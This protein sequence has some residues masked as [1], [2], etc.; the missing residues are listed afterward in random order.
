ML[1]EILPQAVSSRYPL[2]VSYHALPLV[3]TFM[4]VLYPV[5]RPLSLLLDFVLGAP[6]RTIYANEEFTHLLE[7]HRQAGALDDEQSKIMTGAINFKTATVRDCYT[8]IEKLYA[9]EMDEVINRQKMKEIFTSGYSRIPVYAKDRRRTVGM[10]L[11]KDLILVDPKQRRTVGE[12]AG[13]FER[14]P[15]FFTLDQTLDVA[16]ELFKQGRSHC[17]I[18]EV[19]NGPNMD[20][21]GMVTLEDIMEEI[22]HAEIKDE[23]EDPVSQRL[24]TNDPTFVDRIVNLTK[25]S[26]WRPRG[27]RSEPESSDSDEESFNDSIAR[28]QRPLKLLAPRIAPLP[29]NKRLVRVVSDACNLLA[30]RLQ[31]IVKEVQVLDALGI[32]FNTI[33]LPEM[34]VSITGNVDVGGQDKA[35]VPWYSQERDSYSAVF[36]VSLFVRALDGTGISRRVVFNSSDAL[37]EAVYANDGKLLATRR[38]KLSSDDNDVDLALR[39]M[40]SDPSLPTSPMESPALKFIRSR[41]SGSPKAASPRALSSAQ[42]APANDDDDDDFASSRELKLRGQVPDSP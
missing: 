20:T 37:K 13:I 23:T 4:F 9:L 42:V 32:D 28:S 25:L 10:I 34:N 3:Y 11:V 30:L 38:R 41:S 19:P 35:P 26:K 31:S 8:P 14:T 27:T 29:A 6:L 40:P 18:V 36:T 24:I 17:A 21:V 33:A 39:K 7:L 16:L 12:V 2:V 15:L 5:A 22:L 1:G